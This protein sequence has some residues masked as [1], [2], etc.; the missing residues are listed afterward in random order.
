LD[1]DHP[2][3]GVNF[4]RRN[5]RKRQLAGTMSGGEQKMLAFARALVARPKLLLLDEPSMGLAPKVVAE[6]ATLIRDIRRE[7]LT[8]LL[9]EQNAALAL[10]VADE[11]LVL[12]TGEIAL[13]ARAAD[14]IAHPRVRELYLGG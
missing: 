8:V 3:T 9:V 1:A 14:L 10:A 4:P 6:I 13:R 5:T 12:E 11:G 7:G 2:S